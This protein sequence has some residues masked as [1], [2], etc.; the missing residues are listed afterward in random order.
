MFYLITIFLFVILILYK[1]RDT[2]PKKI[3][4]VEKMAETITFWAK[5]HREKNKLK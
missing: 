2:T 5:W 4:G 3:E 1:N